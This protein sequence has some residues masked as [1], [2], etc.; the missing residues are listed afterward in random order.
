VEWIREGAILPPSGSGDPDSLR[1]IRLW[2]L[3]Q[4]DGTLRMSH[5]CAMLTA[6]RWCN[7]RDL[8]WRLAKLSS[9]ARAELYLVLS[10]RPESRPEAVGRLYS[11]DRT[12]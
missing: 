12:R 3:E 6:V 2:V 11:D 8:A 7:G 1:A 4:A 10:A 5:V 9:G